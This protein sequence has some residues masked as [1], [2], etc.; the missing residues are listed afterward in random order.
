MSNASIGYNTRFA[1]ENS[2]GSGVFVELAEVYSVTPPEI[3]I[4]QVEV[5]H[6][7]SPGRSKEYIPAMTDNGT[8]SAE[9][10]FIPNSLTDQRLEALLAAGT[11]LAMRITYPN[12]V[13]VTFQA[14][15]ATYSK[16]IPL[17]DRMTATAG[18]RVSG[19]I[20]IAAGSA[21]TNTVLPAISGTVQ[22]GQTLTAFSGVWTGGPTF[23]YVWQEQISSTWT[24]IAGATAQT[25]VVPGGSTVGRPL[26]VIVTGTNAAGS[27]SA[28]SAATVNVI[29]A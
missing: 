17:E 7:L 27:A 21:P 16:G 14:S 24:A 10:N 28:T 18:F 1:I 6:F 5:T 22:E 25:L 12:A 11:V 15:V 20:T 13:T 4:D 2:P 8:A 9:M 26:R 19:A 29:A 23:T 3:S